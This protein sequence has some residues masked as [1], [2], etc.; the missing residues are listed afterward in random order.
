MA[1]MAHLEYIKRVEFSFIPL[2]AEIAMLFLAAIR[3]L[4]EKGT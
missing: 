4:F 3:E 1:G 2:D